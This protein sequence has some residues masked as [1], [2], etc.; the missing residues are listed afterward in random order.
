MVIRK[1]PR[2]AHL[3]TLDT[4][5]VLGL[6]QRFFT[7][8]ASAQTVWGLIDGSMNIDGIITTVSATTCLASGVIAPGIKKVINRFIDAGLVEKL[9]ING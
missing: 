7:L 4:G 2:V 9:P 8:N 1:N 6:D 5:I 3:C